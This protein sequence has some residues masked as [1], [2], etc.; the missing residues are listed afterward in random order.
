MFHKKVV[1]KIT[2]HIL[3]SVTFFSENCT[4]YVIMSKNMVEAKGPQMT[5]QYGAYA[6]RAEL[7][8]L[9]ALMPMQTPTRPGTLKHARTYDH[10]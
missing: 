9:H 7:A 2:T 6:L 8:R 5:S 3:C 4:I 10:A 1:D